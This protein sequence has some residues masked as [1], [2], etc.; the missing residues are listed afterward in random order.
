MK[1]EDFILTVVFVFV[2]TFGY[3]GWYMAELDNEL[4]QQELTSLKYTSSEIRGLNK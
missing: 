1:K 2:V 4:L 3:F